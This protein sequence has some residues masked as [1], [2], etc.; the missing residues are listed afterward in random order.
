MYKGAG[1]KS[2]G[3]RACIGEQAGAPEVPRDGEVGVATLDVGGEFFDHI[4]GNTLG[5]EHTMT[6]LHIHS[7]HSYESMLCTSS[8]A[9]GTDR[10]EMER[11]GGGECENALEYHS[12]RP[13]AIKEGFAFLWKQ[14]K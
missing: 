12:P 2:K 5:A 6:L 10:L 4:I 11:L 7:K 3:S 8:S 9:Y 13:A 14:Q 1:P